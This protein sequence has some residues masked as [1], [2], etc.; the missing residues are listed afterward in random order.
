VLQ[1]L[2]HRWI[3]AGLLLQLPQRAHGVVVALLEV[4]RTNGSD[5]AMIPRIVIARVR[6]RPAVR[7]PILEAAVAHAAIVRA[8]AALRTGAALG[9]LSLLLAALLLAT[10]LV[11][12]LL[13]SA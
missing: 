6:T 13:L 12:A 4:L 3:H 9:A 2:R 7:V 1:I 11:A 5:A 10:L 8:P